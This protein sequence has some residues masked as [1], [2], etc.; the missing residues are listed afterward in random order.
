MV[1]TGTKRSVNG[2]RLDVLLTEHGA[3]FPK[4]C[5]REDDYK[6]VVSKTVTK[7]RKRKRTSDNL[8]STV[9]PS[10]SVRPFARPVHPPSH[11]YS[12]IMPCQPRQKVQRRVV[13]D[14]GMYRWQCVTPW[15]L[16]A[17]CQFVCEMTSLASAFR[18]LRRST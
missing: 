17:G 12:R 7:E 9:R 3:E 11:I 4:L 2:Q 1:K 8:D 10:H 6:R 16:R 15:R 13:A 14:G 5:S 18:R